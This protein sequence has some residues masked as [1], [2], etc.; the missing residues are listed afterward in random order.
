MSVSEFVP[1]VHALK[2]STINMLRYLTKICTVTPFKAEKRYQDLGKKCS[3]FIKLLEGVVSH[4]NYISIG[5]SIKKL[6]LKHD[7]PRL[8]MEKNQDA[9]LILNPFD[10][11]SDYKNLCS[12]M[13]ITSSDFDTIKSL[14][15]HDRLTEEHKKPIWNCLNV[16]V[17]SSMDM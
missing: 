17:E 8:I 9:L 14:L 11:G 7:I 13:N 10:I 12:N 5:Q 15:N 2:G 1:Q 16:I 6:A 4:A 3:L